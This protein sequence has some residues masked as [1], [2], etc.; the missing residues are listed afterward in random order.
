M[1]G[2]NVTGLAAGTL[3]GV[4]VNRA[5]QHKCIYERVPKA[6]RK[7]QALAFG[8]SFGNVTGCPCPVENGWTRA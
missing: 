3:R 6:L 5:D 1:S 8:V 4:C 7:W 2:H